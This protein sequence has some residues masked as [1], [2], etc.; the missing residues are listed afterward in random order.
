MTWRPKASRRRC[1]CAGRGA[2]RPAVGQ[3]VDGQVAAV[4]RGTRRPTRRM[5]MRSSAPAV[6]ST[7]TVSR[8]F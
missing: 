7:V 8:L 2:A 5:M 6:S 3:L 1:A 4:R